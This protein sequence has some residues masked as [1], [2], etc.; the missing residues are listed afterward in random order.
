MMMPLRQKNGCRRPPVP[1]PPQAGRRTALAAPSWIV[2]RRGPRLL[3]P[4][5][6]VSLA[7]VRQRQ[8]RDQMR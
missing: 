4:M 2:R 7:G 8:V 5:L 3:P 1:A 6:V